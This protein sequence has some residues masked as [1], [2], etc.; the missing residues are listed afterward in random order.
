M[1]KLLILTALLFSL[2]TFGQPPLGFKIDNYY[3]LM[4]MNDFKTVAYLK[5]DSSLVVIDS[6]ATI[7]QLIASIKNMQEQNTVLY[8]AQNI[9]RYVTT[10]GYVLNKHRVE[11]NAAI[12][13][14][15]KV[16]NQKIKY[17]KM[18]NLEILIRDINGKALGWVK[19]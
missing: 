15:F 10:R 18:L 3:E 16:T 19:Q 17:D 2:T 8:E 13:K 4:I 5:K 9:L 11:F 14:Y 7:K 12:E 6:L 1:K